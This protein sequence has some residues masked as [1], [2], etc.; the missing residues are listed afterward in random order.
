MKLFK[1]SV[2]LSIFLSV[3]CKN[4]TISNQNILTG[5]YEIK[6]AIIKTKI[7]I[8]GFSEMNI[9]LLFDDYGR[10]HKQITNNIMTTGL[11]KD[12][13][14]LYSL[15]QDDYIYT[16][17]NTTNSGTSIHLSPDDEDIFNTGFNFKKIDNSL[18][19]K[20]QLK[21]IGT[22]TIQG[23]NTTVYSL[24]ING[25]KLKYYIWKNIP[26]EFEIQ[27]EDKTIQSKLVNIDE[28]P[29]FDKETFEVPKGITFEKE[30]QETAGIFGH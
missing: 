13:V 22:K 20:Y 10:L 17:D 19:E 6:K 12:T 25:N 23:K 7:S 27:L 9:Q 30:H 21:E 16:W 11:G 5:K 26:L 3:A 29:K 8:P 28:Y 1:I 14:I 24:I 15:I 2:L 18:K 4:K